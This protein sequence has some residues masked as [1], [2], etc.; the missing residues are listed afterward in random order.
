MNTLELVEVIMRLQAGQGGNAVPTGA[1]QRALDW[2][3]GRFYR[4]LKQ[5]RDYGF[6]YQPM[7]GLVMISGMFFDTITTFHDAIMD[8]DEPHVQRELPLKRL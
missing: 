1:V 7:Q 6:V 2:K 5:A 8:A 3:S 4:A